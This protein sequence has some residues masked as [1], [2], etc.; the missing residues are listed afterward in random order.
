VLS[1]LDGVD[2]LD[3][4]RRAAAQAAEEFRGE[5]EE[6][7]AKLARQAARLLPEQGV[8]LTVSSSSTVRAAV[9]KAGRGA[10]LRVICLESRPMAEGQAQARA[11]AAAGVPVTFAVDAAAEALL[12]GCAAVLLGADSLGDQGAV[13]KVGS[14]AVVRA[15]RIYDVPVWVLADQT[16][17]LPPGFPQVVGD[18]RPG[19]EVWNA[20]MGIRIW[21]RYFEIIPDTLI[22]QVISDTGVSVPDEVHSARRRLPVPPELAAWASWRRGDPDAGADELH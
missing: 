19:D 11:L 15:A 18:D 22:D 4:G 3:E 7:T 5:V 16:K 1:A 17:L 14:R 13:N 8:V 2:G 6:R 21:N 20:P 10:D 12:P 9:V